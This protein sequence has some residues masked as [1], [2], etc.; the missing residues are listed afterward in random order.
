MYQ[1]GEFVVYGIQGVCRVL[2]TE[3]QLVN[4]KRVEYL[5]LE[6]ITREKSRFYLPTQNPNAIG[7]LC[8]VLTRKELNDLLD[9]AQINE[10]CWIK[11]ESLRKQR[12]RDLLSAA[13]R[14]SLMQ[15][16]RSLYRYQSE[17][18]SNGK[19]IHQCDEYFLHDAERLLSSEIGLVMELS[20]EEA[21]QYLRNR[22]K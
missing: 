2:G 3:K 16:L 13:D 20:P 9:C 21:K 7:K 15:M 1:I 11:E 5:I 17:L 22:L 14:I 19:R 12:Y 10:D 6:P 18:I 8:P 4:R